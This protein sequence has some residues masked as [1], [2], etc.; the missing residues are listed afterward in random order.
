MRGPKQGLVGPAHFSRNRKSRNVSSVNSFVKQQATDQSSYWAAMP[1]FMGIDGGGSRTTAC[2]ADEKGRI[3]SRET[4]GPSN[5]CKVGWAT[6]QR[7]LLAA[8]RGAVRKSGLGRQ[9]LDALCAGIA[10]VDRPS[11]RR[12][13]E[14]GLRRA[15]PA[16]HYLVTTDG[17]TALEAGLGGSSGLIVIS[18]TGSIAYARAED[19]RV[20][21]CGGWGTVFDD[22][23][24]GYDIGRKAVGAALRDLDGRGAKTRLRDNLCK[25]LNLGTITEAVGAALPPHRIAALF[26]VVERVA[27]D[28]DAV[29]RKICQDAGKDL[30]D[31][32]RA[33]LKRMDGLDPRLRVVCAG[34]VLESSL[35]VRR[36]FAR[37]LRHDAPRIRITVLHREAVEGA[38]A[39]A[40]A[41]AGGKQSASW[42]P[43][44]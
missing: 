32:A 7:H 4:S 5:P 21:R 9:R 33:L 40:K 18:G 26:P 28:G 12:K 2:L 35:R 36:S 25:A 43:E 42:K 17:I 6:A 22:A 3:L 23:G 19:G 38:L 24:S 31:L 29:A 16:R 14:A 11:T 20:L 30:A 44:A 39:L 13:L 15:I 41:L 37:D 27:R 34:G 1:C 10:G 8:A